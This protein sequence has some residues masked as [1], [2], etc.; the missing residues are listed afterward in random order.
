ML[1]RKSLGV[2]TLSMVSL[3]C[4]GGEE[5]YHSRSINALE[6]EA[7]QSSDAYRDV[8]GVLAH[9]D[10][11]IDLSQG[12]VWTTPDPTVLSAVVPVEHA[13]PGKS[14]QFS[15]LI[16]DLKE[17]VVVASSLNPN[18]A[19]VPESL[20]GE[21]FSSQSQ[22]LGTCSGWGPWYTVSSYC[23]WHILCLGDAT[24]LHR[25]RTRTCWYNGNSWTEYDNTTVRNKCG[26]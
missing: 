3:N 6:V 5:A 23:T 17:G 19:F 16:V 7:I 4:G 10:E 9:Q 1:N 25:Q 13:L 21:Q 15:E 2:L 22:A 18:D 12:E 8:A 14:A 20:D 26:C 24:M 11:V